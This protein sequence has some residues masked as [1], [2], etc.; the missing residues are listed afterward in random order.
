MSTPEDRQE[1]NL[2]GQVSS[3]DQNLSAPE[4]DSQTSASASDVLDGFGAPEPTGAAGDVDAP[5]GR[6]A[7]GTP[8]AK[9]GRPRKDGAEGKP[10]S[11]TEVKIRAKKA[12]DTEKAKRMACDTLATNILNMAVGTLVQVVGPEWAPQNDDE[13]KALKGAL[14]DYLYA[15]G[16]VTMSPGT[17]L[18]I[19]VGGYSFAR[20]QHENTRNKFGAFFG[21]FWRGVKT[22]YKRFFP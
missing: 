7:D 3:T 16:K 8:K 20:F 5:W 17:V 21:G 14:S 12:D 11:A 13:S 2:D 9:P 6:R 4:L 19:A 22:V 18:A 10:M 1:S 15:Q